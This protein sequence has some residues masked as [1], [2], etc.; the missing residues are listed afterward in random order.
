MLIGVTNRFEESVG[1]LLGS[2]LHRNGTGFSFGYE[3]G[4]SPDSKLVVTSNGDNAV[5]W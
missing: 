1:A 2:L 5:L 3:I 4:F